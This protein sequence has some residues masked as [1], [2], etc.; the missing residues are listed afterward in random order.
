[1]VSST[2]ITEFYNGDITNTKINKSIFDVNDIFFDR[3]FHISSSMIKY[4]DLANLLTKF[5]LSGN[6]KYFLDKSIMI[7][8]ALNGEILVIDNKSFYHRFQKGVTSRKKFSQEIFLEKNL[9]YLELTKGYSKAKKL[10]VMFQVDILISKIK[11]GNDLFSSIRNFPL[12]KF[13]L[14]YPNKFKFFKKLILKKINV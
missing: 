2:Y 6:Y 10:N 7:N 11:S 12:I 1:M 8:S 4:E 9:C 3:Q 5:K 14:Y 13:I